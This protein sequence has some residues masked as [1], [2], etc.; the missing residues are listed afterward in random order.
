MAE[1]SDK[2]VATKAD[3]AEGRPP[4]S[5]DSQLGN[6]FIDGAL[7]HLNTIAP[8]ASNEVDRGEPA[9]M[10]NVWGSH[11]LQTFQLTIFYFWFLVSSR[12]E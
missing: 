7:D 11:L 1:S 10:K 3:R 4:L 2:T 9:S 12:E 8:G 5:T 6:V